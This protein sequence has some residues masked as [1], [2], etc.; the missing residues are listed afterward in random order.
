MWPT[1]QARRHEARSWGKE[2]GQQIPPPPYRGVFAQGSCPEELIIFAYLFAHLLFLPSLCLRALEIAS[3]YFGQFGIGYEFRDDIFARSKAEVLL[4]RSKV[5]LKALGYFIKP[6]SVGQASG[7][8]LVEVG[9]SDFVS[10]RGSSGFGLR[11][12][13]HIFG[14][15]F[16]PADCARCFGVGD[17]F[18]VGLGFLVFLGPMESG[19]AFRGDEFED[20]VGAD[21]LEA[22][23]GA[24]PVSP[25]DGAGAQVGQFPGAPGGFFLAFGGFVGVMDD[26]GGAVVFVEQGVDEVTEEVAYV[27][28]F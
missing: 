22:D 1:G 3:I 21:G 4:D 9:E 16:V 26:D 10:F 24:R 17:E 6:L 25:L 15:G 7:A 23:D 20:G 18:G 28:L 12:F 5:I 13:G 8:E 27:L 11:F 2:P 14:G 19:A